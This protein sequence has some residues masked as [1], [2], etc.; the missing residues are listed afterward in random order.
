MTENYAVKNYP[1]FMYA[2]FFKRLAAFMIDGLISGF[3][4]TIVGLFFSFLH[5]KEDYIDIDIVLN[6]AVYFIYYIL[7]TKFNRGQTIGKMIMNI[8][9][10]S[11]NGE[12]LGFFQVLVRELFVRY[13]QNVLWIL[14][15][16]I[17]L[18]S[19]KKSV[20]DYFADTFV[21]NCDVYEVKEK[22][23]TPEVL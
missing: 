10:V 11:A 5:F 14:Y 16:A 4:F 12:K 18:N 13:I 17:P 6:S 19:K 3:I 2:G 9:V 23:D 21:V 15:L 22:F 20:A 7:F 8:R 1:T